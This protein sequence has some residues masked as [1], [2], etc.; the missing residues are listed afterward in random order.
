M[1]RCCFSS[2]SADTSSTWASYKEDYRRDHQRILSYNDP[3]AHKINGRVFKPDSSLLPTN[4]PLPFPI[5]E[6]FNLNAEPVKIPVDQTCDVKL[7][8]LSLRGGFDYV[9]SWVDPFEAEFKDNKRVEIVEICLHDYGFLKYFRSSFI[10]NLKLEVPESNFQ[11]T[12]LSFGNAYEVA[13]NLLL[14]NKYTGYVY[15]VD[16]YNRV[17]WRGC[18]L[19]LSTPKGGGEEGVV[20]EEIESLVRCTRELLQEK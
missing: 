3:L 10:K 5:I 2:S 1:S 19:T 16:K 11:R 9:K 8:G 4:D 17:R 15:L 7:I 14:P 13:V 18:G 20:Q 6:G 12:V